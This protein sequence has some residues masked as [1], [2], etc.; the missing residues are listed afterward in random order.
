[1][2]SNCASNQPARWS[3][4]LAAVW[5]LAVCSAA[6]HSGSGSLIIDEAVLMTRGALDDSATREVKV[7]AGS[8]LLV[9]VEEN[10]TDVKLVLDA[11]ARDGTSLGAPIE[12]ENN[13]QGESFEGAV[14]DVYGADRVLLTLRAP[15]DS[16]KPGTVRL[17][18]I[19]FSRKAL[20]EPVTEA[21][22][23]AMRSWTQATRADLTATTATDEA[24][25]AIGK[26]IAILE[27]P[28]VADLASAA[29]ARLVRARILYYHELNPREARA[30]ARR[31]A[32]VFASPVV[33]DPLNAAR[34][35]RLEAAALQ[36]IALNSTAENPTAQQ[37]DVEARRLLGTLV[38]D[39]SPLDLVGRARARNLLGLQDYNA[40]AWGAAR[41]H[42]DDALK[43]YRA[44]GNRTGALQSLRNLALLENSRGDYQRAAVAY[45]SLLKEKDLVTDPDE[46]A[47]L[48]INAAT[49][50]MNA[51]RVDDA[52]MQFRVAIDFTRRKSLGL[53]KGRAL[54]GLGV[55]YWKLGDSAQAGSFL[56]EAL[57]VR[58]ELVDNA[59]MFESLR[60]NGMLSRESGDFTGALAMHREAQ[61]R[62]PNALSHMRVKLELAKDLA[63]TADLAGA[64]RECR[65]AL[66]VK[67]EFA[68]HPAR[69]EVK[70]ALADF[71]AQSGGKDAGAVAEATELANQVLQA[72][73][74]TVDAPLEIAARQVLAEL[75]IAKHDDAAA[76]EHLERSIDL[77]LRYRNL[78]TNPELQITA[79]ARNAR[80]FQTYIDFEMRGAVQAPRSAELRLASTREIRALL[81][82]ESARA[83]NFGANGHDGFDRDSQ[84]LEALLDQ[85]AAKRVRVATLL[86]RSSPP[87]RQINLL[88]LEMADIRSQIDRERLSKEPRDGRAPN[89]SLV[90]PRAPA[91]AVDVLQLSYALGASRAYLWV[92]EQDRVR[93]AVISASR[94][95][96]E[97][98][99]DNLFAIDRIQAPLAFERS[100]AKLADLLLP[101][102]VTTPARHIEIVADGKLGAL[103]LAAMVVSTRPHLLT[104]DGAVTIISS[105]LKKPR[106]QRRP[107]RAWRM[108]SLGAGPRA[109]EQNG[110][111]PDAQLFPEL[112]F[113]TS[114]SEAVNEI[115]SKATSDVRTKLLKGGD[116]SIGS[117][118]D[119]WR[120]GADVVHIATHG[121]SDLRQ[122][123]ASLLEFPTTG[124][125]EKSPYLT[126]GQI[127]LWRGDVGLVYLSA[128][129]TARG[130]AR[131]AV[132]MPGLQQAFL[133]AGAHYV[134]A[135]LWTVED[136]YAKEFALDFY[137]RLRAGASAPQA[138][139]ATQRGWLSS[140]KEAG[141]GKQGRRRITASAF[142]IFQ[143]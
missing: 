2:C 104:R 101:Q 88:Q 76:R 138:L 43:D 18:G 83:A 47:T 105:V 91:L 37:A 4:L 109:D 108:V 62:A 25:P 134:I 132:G 66:S 59:G 117:L 6:E 115:W 35:V 12:V 81:A 71:L 124:K 16:L 96:L 19:E 54:H 74:A 48:L 50:F 36:E 102:E 17:R 42:F 98:A 143:E 68:E 110:R 135:T 103:P 130:P 123:L 85:L 67:L 49:A 3:L 86:E 107:A 120:Q 141:Q 14:L 15:S 142:A 73:I 33:N 8:A 38:S 51:G 5:W 1:M 28:P 128:C 32:A 70:V 26:A 131:F 113:A 111:R 39:D 119:A 93:V 129:E 87:I 46:H 44:V 65:E 82:L 24:L 58:R 125:A 30:E 40:L 45:D 21:R 34:A 136:E 22:M 89:D 61:L 99:I 80:A 95:E 72:A 56:A 84:R 27:G 7:H 94:D 106:E 121:L 31:A 100:T 20:A 112:H 137:Q 75:L 90:N 79:L 41:P 133:H 55:L 118:S 139:A 77:A 9:T 10:G 127:Q 114:E 60:A 97:R 116:A 78:S 92:R 13:L 23:S 122:P 69:S 29:K 57:R 126:A 53:P 63:A 52:L 11:L 140:T 64:T